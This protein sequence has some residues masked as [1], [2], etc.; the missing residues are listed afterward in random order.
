M[1]QKP[2]TYFWLK[3]PSG[4]YRLQPPSGYQF[5]AEE[6]LMRERIKFTLVK[7]GLVVPTQKD[8]WNERIVRRLGEQYRV[9]PNISLGLFGGAS[10]FG[11][12]PLDRLIEL[13]PMFDPN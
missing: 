12:R 2:Q 7:G 13:V 8:L 9:S 6:V 10:F 4:F 11:L 1:D 5:C 3:E